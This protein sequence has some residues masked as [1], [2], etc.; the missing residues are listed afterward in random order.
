V[1]SVR[2][3][4]PLLTSILDAEIRQEGSIVN[5]ENNWIATFN[6]PIFENSVQDPKF[7]YIVTLGR[8]VNAIL[9]VHSVQSRGA[10]NTEANKRDRFNS[11]LFGSAL[12]F[13][14]LNLIEVMLT[15][16]SQDEVFQTG[17][18]NLLYDETAKQIKKAHL[19]DV[20]H[21]A[22]F[23]FD[24]KAF[25]EAL[26]KTK[27]Y[28]CPF[29]AARG[30]GRLSF[31]YQLPDMVAA[32]ILVGLPCDSENFMS[33]LGEAMGKT[34]RLVERFVEA[35]EALIVHYLHQW[36]YVRMEDQSY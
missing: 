32:E 23:H 31:N 26:Q 25:G 33:I 8:A 22:V 10:E 20:R 19:K 36:G 14:C 7:A 18:R 34:S 15:P 24:P 35:S 30:T 17:L 4:Y 11:F 21:Q 28:D 16:F 12:M 2:S 29:V 3:A 13:E 9:F 1:S 5:E 6:R 27:F